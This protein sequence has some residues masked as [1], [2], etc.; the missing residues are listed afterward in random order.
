[1]MKSFDDRLTEVGGFGPGFDFVRIAL[2]FGVVG[3]HAFAVVV[4]STDAGKMT[5]AWLSVRSIVPMF[6]ALSGFLV[7]G[8]ALRLPL[9]QYILNRVFRI[10]PALGVDILLS[11]MILGPIF[12]VFT[13]QEYFTGREFFAYFLNIFGAVRYFLP[14]VFLSNPIAG[15]VNG[16]LWTVPYE[17]GCYVVMSVMIWLGLIR[18][19]RLTSVLAVGWLLVACLVHWF[20]FKTGIAF[21]DKVINFLFRQFGSSLIPFFLGGSALYLLKGHIPFDGRIAA[22]IIAAVLLVSFGLD[23][24]VWWNHPLTQL[25]SMGPLVYLVMYF[26]LLALPKIPMF[27]RGDYS[28]G[29]YLYHFPILQ[30]MQ[31]L[32]GMTSGIAM[33][34][35]AIIPVTLMAMFSWHTIEKPILKQ[36]KRFSLVGARIANEG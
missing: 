36:R 34:L 31:Q 19:A 9:K 21:V 35:A 5:P 13:L 24:R 32:F 7:T 33:F 28:Y 12:T 17:I 4:G 22:A 20:A 27:D 26:G 16:S 18:S 8:S 2:A 25:L 15:V 29:V 30:A 14:G 1:M 23:G 11:A 3:W 6:F 10:L